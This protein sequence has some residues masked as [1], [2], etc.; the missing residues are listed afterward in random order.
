MGKTRKPIPVLPPP[1]KSRK[2][3]RQITTAFHK[4]TK[5]Q[6]QVKSDDGLSEREK[7]QRLTQLQRELDGIGGREAYQSASLLSV[8]YHNT[9]KWVTQQL[10][11]MGMRPAKGAPPL[12]LLEVGAINDR[13]LSVPWLRVR[14]IDLRAAHPRVER[15]DFFDL[16]PRG[17][18]DAAA[19]AMVLNCVPEPARRG[20][21]L[22][23]LRR[24]LRPGGALLLALP[25]L[26]LTNSRCMSAPRFAAILAHAG[27][28]VVAERRSPRVAFYVLRAAREPPPDGAP[29]RFAHGDHGRPGRGRM[30]FSV[31]L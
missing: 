20:A 12:N 15:A 17:A 29:P 8:Q 23:R 4:L 30:D 2:R 31:E 19:L 3:A 18:F 11:H 22:A 28:D 1:L 9:S 16:A 7:Q 6:A 14:A 24:H 5:Q 26:C 27:F 21:M 10:E 25:L 13:L